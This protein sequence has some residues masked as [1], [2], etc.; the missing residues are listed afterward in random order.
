MV[1]PSESQYNDRD[2]MVRRSTRAA[3]HARDQVQSALDGLLSDDD[4]S[5]RSPPSRGYD[6]VGSALSPVP[7]AGGRRRSYA[8][9]EPI[10]IDA[11]DPQRYQSPDLLSSGRKSSAM[12]LETGGY[13]P[14]AAGGR[15]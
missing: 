3:D 8:P 2:S 10:S 9:P 6:P 12:T 11:T 1:Q 14:T 15:R 13:T 7:S 4:I 5:N